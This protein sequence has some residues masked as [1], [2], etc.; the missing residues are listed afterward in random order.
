[1]TDFFLDASQIFEFLPLTTIDQKYC[2]SRLSVWKGMQ[3]CR[4]TTHQS[5]KPNSIH[6]IEH[7]QFARNYSLYN[8][9]TNPEMAV[10]TVPKTA[11]KDC[12]E[13]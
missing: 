1:M 9:V 6:L 13:P 4:T 11:V 3:E 10:R 7:P 2:S 12:D 8:K 5:N